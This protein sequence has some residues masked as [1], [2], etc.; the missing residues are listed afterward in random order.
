MSLNKW[1]RSRTWL[2]SHGPYPHNELRIGEMA[3]RITTS[4]ELWTNQVATLSTDR[5][6]VV[7]SFT[8]QPVM[9][10]ATRSSLVSMLTRRAQLRLAKL[11][12]LR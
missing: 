3:S 9:Y 8:A 10:G 6:W 12:Y 7:A 4:R 1:L 11:Q 2:R 5:E